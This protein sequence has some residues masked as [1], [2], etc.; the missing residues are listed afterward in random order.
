[1]RHPPE[2]RHSATFVEPPASCPREEGLLRRGLFRRMAGG[3]SAL[4]AGGWGDEAR[5]RGKLRN[6]AEKRPGRGAQ[7]AGQRDSNSH[8]K[9]R[10]WKG[11]LRP[12]QNLQ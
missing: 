3:E 5:S 4:Q 9:C 12:V 10:G 2:K 7:R 11:R 1:M 8:Q 6:E